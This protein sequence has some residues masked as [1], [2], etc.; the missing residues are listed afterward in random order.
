MDRV[1]ERHALAAVTSETRSCTI[2]AGLQS[3]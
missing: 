1:G 3:A 2:L